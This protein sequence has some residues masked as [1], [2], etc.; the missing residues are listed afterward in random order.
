MANLK[1]VKSALKYIEIDAKEHVGRFS[2]TMFVSTRTMIAI[3]EAFRELDKRAEAAEADHDNVISQS[4]E[5][6]KKLM[7]TEAN[8]AELANQEP[9]AEVNHDGTFYGFKALENIPEGNYQLYT[10]PAPAA[11]PQGWKLVPVEPNQVMC[12]IAHIGIDPCTG[13]T[14]EPEYYSINGEYAAKVYRAMLAAAPDCAEM[15]R[16]IEDNNK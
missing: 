16:R 15:L 11:A 7:A 10:R 9:V 3:A 12:D 1:R 8:L 5:L 14:D 13:I 6:Y 4:D 2:P